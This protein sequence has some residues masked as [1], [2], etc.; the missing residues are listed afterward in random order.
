ML[1]P[2]ALYGSKLPLRL[3][4]SIPFTGFPEPPRV[5]LAA[6]HFRLD[7][8]CELTGKPALG[9]IWLSGEWCFLSGSPKSGGFKALQPVRLLLNTT[10]EDNKARN[11]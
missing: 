4:E 9:G 2:K 8:L 1:F 7:R 5:T 10:P 6:P 3:L 11:T